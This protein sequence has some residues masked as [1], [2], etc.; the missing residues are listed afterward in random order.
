[1]TLYLTPDPV[2]NHLLEED[3]FALIVG[4]LLDQQIPMERAF[5]AP[6]LLDERLRAAGH[7]G[8]TPLIIARLPEDA[9]IEL[10][11][12]KPALH[13]FPKAMAVKVQALA[14][15]IADSY[16][17]DT[18]SL[19]RTAA[20][21]EELVSRLRSLEGFGADKAKIFAA[22]LAKRLGVRPPGWEAA[23]APF[24][25]PGTYMSVADSVDPDALDRVRAYKAQMKQ[26]ARR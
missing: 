17:G 23:T 24:G 7:D 21:G 22:L 9:L 25:Q 2:A 26:A 18:A 19:W 11:A 5:G 14:H 10:F 15:T 4:M 12:A 13:R 8:L 16:D 1:V 20:S 3:P 6:K